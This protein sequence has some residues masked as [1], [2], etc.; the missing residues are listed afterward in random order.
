[1][2]STNAYPVPNSTQSYWRSELHEIDNLRSTKHLP[3][4][5]DVLIVGAGISGVSTAYHLLNDN[6]SPPS[7]VLLEAREVCSGATGRN[8][9]HLMATQISL[10]KI[11]RDHDVDTAREISNFKRDQVF[12]LKSV[13][14]KEKLDC[15]AVLTRYFETFLTQ[16]HADEIKKQYDGQL[17]AGLDFIQ[18][19]D[20]VGPKH[21]EIV[22]PK[23]ESSRSAVLR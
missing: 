12:A 9:G 16:S 17:K 21:V 4:E 7:V 11:I 3:N 10:D 15:D 8:G 23:I 13:V 19:M 14:E 22:I 18:D 1:M 5:C 2:E 6:P 20:F